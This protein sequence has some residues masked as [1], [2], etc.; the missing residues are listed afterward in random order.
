MSDNLLNILTRSLRWDIFVRL[1]EDKMCINEISSCLQIL[2]DFPFPRNWLEFIFKKKICCFFKRI[3]VSC[4]V[5]GEFNS[6][7]FG[8]VH[9]TK[10]LI[11][12][13]LLNGLIVLNEFCIWDLIECFCLYELTIENSICGQFC[14]R[15]W[16]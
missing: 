6:F 11:I 16:S 13:R 7:G 9:S 4:F 5:T 3:L 2:F 10:G 1:H 8:R 15:Q 14:Y 12:Y